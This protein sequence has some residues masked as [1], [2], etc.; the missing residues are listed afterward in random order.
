MKFFSNTN[1]PFFSKGYLVIYPDV[2]NSGI[3]SYKHYKKYGK[4]EGRDNGLNPPAGL[5]FR[6]GYELMYP[7]VT[8]SGIDS[9]VHYAKYG[10]HEG[11]DNGFN[12]PSDVFF[13]EGFE[14]MYP[15]V[16]A[17]GI[18]SWVHYAKYGIH[19]GRN[20]G[21]NPPSDVFFREGYEL[22]YQD[23]AASGIDSW[24]HYAKYGIHEGRDNGFNPPSDV[25]FREGFE[26]MY[27]DVTASGID[28]WVHYAKYGIHEGR[29]NGLNPPEDL[30]FREGY[31]LMY[32]DVTAAGIDSWVHYAKYGIKESRDNGL[33][34]P[35]ELFFREGYELMYPDVTASNVDSWVHYAKYGIK[36]GH[37]NGLNPPESLFSKEFYQFLHSDVE[38][39]GNNP[40]IYYVKNYNNDLKN[41]I[42]PI[43][44]K[45]N[46][47]KDAGSQNTVLFISHEL[48]VTGAPYC[49]NQ[50]A[51]LLAEAG[52][53]IEIWTLPRII[54]PHIFDDLDC[55]IYVVPKIAED[56]KDL[57]S[58]I[59]KF[60]F[61]ICNTTLTA[62]YANYLMNKGVN[63]LWIIHECKFIP[64][65][66]NDIG[67]NTSILEKCKT[68]TYVVSE[69][70]SDYLYNKFNVR[71]PVLHNFI[72]DL[73]NEKRAGNSTGLSED[74]QK[75]I[76]TFCGSMDDNKRLN[77][78]IY[79]FLRLNIWL[80]D[81]WEF[82]IVGSLNKTNEPF[83]G[84]LVDITKPYSNIIWHNKL[85]GNAK[86]AVFN[87]TDVFLVP[88]KEEPGTL[89]VIEAAMLA[90]TFV[91]T[92]NVGTKYL[93]RDNAGFILDRFDIESI[94]ECI[95]NILSM[96]K[97]TLAE[98]GA[99]ARKNYLATSSREIFKKNFYSII[100]KLNTA[101]QFNAA[102]S[103]GITDLLSTEDHLVPNCRTDGDN[104]IILRNVNLH[105]E[106]RLNCDSNNLNLVNEYLTNNHKTVYVI[107][108]VHNNFKFL[109]PLFDSLKV[110][111]DVPH[112]F[113]F[114]DDCSSQ[115]TREWL[116]NNVKN[117]SDC[118]LL[119][120][121]TRQ[122]YVKSVNTAVE[123]AD[124]D[125]VILDPKA[126][127]PPHWLS[128]LVYPLYRD[129]KTATVSPVSNYG[130]LSGY[131]FACR[132]DLNREFLSQL[133]VSKIDSSFTS[134]ADKYINVPHGN[135]I[136]TAVSLKAW[137]TTGCF[138][139]LLYD[140]RSCAD[141]D[142][143]QRA[144]A[145][146]W[147]NTMV[148]DLFIG[149]TGD[150]SPLPEESQAVEGGA[151]RII[152]QLYPDYCTCVHNF[153]RKY[154]FGS[155][156]AQSIYQ[157]AKADNCKFILHDDL[158][159]FSYNSVHDNSMMLI[160][161]NHS[162]DYRF[163]IQYKGITLVMENVSFEDAVKISSEHGLTLE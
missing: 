73:Y 75:I 87:K 157:L 119:E 107:I 12:P 110:N 36:E 40:W 26:L 19:E 109:Q 76:F 63:Y 52:Y 47:G 10:I 20:N 72:D 158:P 149:Y 62:S 89:V 153:F 9:W 48:S 86:L 160:K 24:V 43:V 69:Y 85:V 78:C 50:M 5:F 146:G 91:I 18:D 150:D 92:K 15:D 100:N 61:I 23:V 101:S 83:W 8:A 162:V 93:A 122:G 30:F 121:K 99:A 133:S 29:G 65:F 55:S 103:S 51:K 67:F 28:S 102:N 135:I 38:K 17:S 123:Y 45:Q 124:N 2:Q 145:G 112:K 134:G 21:F 163:V 80:C 59:K 79:A 127:L 143:C 161:K 32:P 125:F 141:I 35:A 159:V 66:L 90:K 152:K 97:K 25:F 95:Q 6:E 46:N 117:R 42:Y 1:E 60:S 144:A 126:E 88:S 130:D 57:D 31:E 71:L 118:I 96:S 120:N 128:R 137:K 49:V 139:E 33:N 58:V 53:K 140:D 68:N 82:N 54:D 111:T 147:K 22:M 27:P 156:L 34:P 129:Q 37:D 132:N 13:R 64:N 4:K 56:F 84:K 7:D 131:P 44:R 151:R 16:T 39:S 106:A 70:V 3:S 98:K 14:L 74:P 154:P 108:V 114:M 113:I 155:Y 81:Q 11:R 105:S 116:D 142:F 138:N 115:E 41:V 94:K 148:P 77:D 104:T 136:C